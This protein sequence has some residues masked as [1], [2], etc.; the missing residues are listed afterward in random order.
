MAIVMCLCDSACTYGK[1]VELV[2]FLLD[3][4]CV[5]INCQGKDG[6]TG[7]SLCWVHLYICVS[8]Y[9]C[10][11]LYLSVCQLYAHLSVTVCRPSFPPV[12]CM[13]TCL[14]VCH[15]L[16][17]F[18]STCLSLFAHLSFHLSV[19]YMTTCLSVFTSLYVLLPLCPPVYHLIHLFF[20]S[21]VCPSVCLPTCLPPCLS[22]ILHCFILLC[23]ENQYLE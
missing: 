19:N 11:S 16:L 6:H 7:Q 8:L 4:D 15:C 10:L 21:P 18:L 14:S 9:P 5:D 23:C 22:T 20:Q 13:T 3:Q 17:T 12:N 1:S 2:K